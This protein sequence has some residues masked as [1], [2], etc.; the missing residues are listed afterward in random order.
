MTA[1][2]DTGVPLIVAL[3]GASPPVKVIVPLVVSLGAGAFEPGASPVR[4][5][6]PDS[7]TT[8]PGPLV[9]TEVMTGAASAMAIVRLAL[10]V[11]PSASVRV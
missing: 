11:V 6:R 2:T 8:V 1:P 4:A 5:G 9:G 7:A 3:T 10:E